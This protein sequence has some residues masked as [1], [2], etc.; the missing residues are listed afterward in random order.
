MGLLSAFV[1]GKMLQKALGGSGA[2]HV[3]RS[4][5]GLFGKKMIIATAAAMLLKRAFRRW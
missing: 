3:G 2:A 4:R 1:K 5:G